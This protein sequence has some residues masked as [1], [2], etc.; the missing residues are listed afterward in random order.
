MVD[1]AQKSLLGK[2]QARPDLVRQVFEKALRDGFLATIEAVRHRL[3]S[4]VPM[5]YSSAG[6]V[7]AVGEG[8]ENF[9][10]G[11]RVACAG[12]GYANHAEM[13]FIPRNLAARVPEGVDFESASFTTV[14]AVALQ[15]LRLA[16]IQIG[17]AVAVIGLGLI[18]LV[19]VQLAKA[20]GC[21]VIGMDP[22]HGRAEL[23]RKLG[24]D[25]VAEDGD[26]FRSAVQRL[27]SGQGA[28]AVLLSA[29]TTGNEPVNLAGEVARDRAV[30]V[31]VGTVG[32]EIPRKLYYEKELDFRV[33]RSYGPGR[34]DHRYEEKGGDYP[35]GYVRWTENRNLQAFLQLLAEDK[36][37]VKPLI[38]HRFQINDAAQAYDLI[39][40]KRDESSLGI[41]ITYPGESEK[42]TADLRSESVQDMS[43]GRRQPTATDT[44]ICTRP[45][46]VA[47]GVLGAGEFARAI[48]LPAMKKV[49][50][51]KLVGVCTGTGVSAGHAAKKFGFQF[52]TTEENEIIHH[53]EITT[54]AI[55]TRHHLHA[56]QVIAALKAGKNVFVEKPLCLNEAELREIFQVYSAISIPQS[57]MPLLMVG[58]NRRFAPMAR[59]LKNFLAS[60]EEPLIMNYR[61]NAGYIPREHWVHDA[62]QG[63]GRAV[64]ELC[65]FVDF[66]IFLA[67]S[68]PEKVYARTLPNVNRYRDD[69]VTVTLEFADGSL[70]TI[71][72]TANGDKRF[73]KER[74]EVFG[75]GAVAV[76]DNFRQLEL[77]RNG[78][79]KVTRSWIGQDKGHRG[80][81][82]SFSQSVLSRG[83][84]PIPLEEIVQGCLA[85]FWSRDSFR[86]NPS[87]ENSGLRNWQEK[88]FGAP[89]AEVTS[90]MVLSGVLKGC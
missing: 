19:L 7:I 48:L 68:L 82:E 20:A 58:Y 35:V 49:S 79:R 80:E 28:D 85:T 86:G 63:G 39:L 41:L 23:A 57:A 70:G 66:L 45:S 6:T 16:D 50:A 11:D 81:W 15:G 37:R 84:S 21:R 75:G 36:V 46:P 3:D 26:G 38:S 22:N 51:V 32:M 12:T 54:V 29:S 2:A 88:V 87:V 14:G 53:P 52:A 43:A 5:G 62:E 40:G 76:L 65:H 34:Y 30:V 13:V 55:L 42:V 74:V 67:G 24:A 17:G 60:I 89:A 83:P 90:Q 31:A 33:S 9:A 8:A 4:P 44:A 71:T 77:I 27:S 64:G 1:L 69:N 25:R 61:V 59:T 10:V 78:R 18:G 56:R 73:P 47:V 72:Y